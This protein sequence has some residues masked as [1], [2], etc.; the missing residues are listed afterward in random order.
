LPLKFAG[1]GY[2]F[3]M[4]DG[5]HNGNHGGALLPKMLRWIWRDYP[6]E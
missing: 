1:Y 6:K 3:G 5:K 2:Q 4:G